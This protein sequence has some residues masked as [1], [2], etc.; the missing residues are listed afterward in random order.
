MTIGRKCAALI[1]A[2]V[3]TLSV[4]GCGGNIDVSKF[5][6]NT[7]VI[8]KD[9]S[10]TEVSVESFGEDYYT[11]EALESFVNAEVDGYNGQHP[12]ASG[13]EK[14]K[15]VTVDTIKVKD[16]SARVVLK[17]ADAQAYRDFNNASLD[18][19][20]ASEL[21]AD[22]RALG[23]KDDKG[24]SIG[25]WSAVEK[26]EDYQAVVIYS[27]LQV[28]VSGKIAY[29]SE[30]VTVTDKSTAKCDSTPAVIVYK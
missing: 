7:L 1:L 21:S 2:A 10:V 27:Q 14:D 26:P 6:E 18:C 25:A 4:T 16:G 29:V 13:K 12:S 19:V 22:A 3:L 9:G 20:K 15:V 30:N 23:F 28:A 8:N 5:A 11:Q 24:E 17:Y